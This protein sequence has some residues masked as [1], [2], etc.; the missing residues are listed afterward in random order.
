MEIRGGRPMSRLSLFAT[1]AV[2]LILPAC[3]SVNT[4]MGL[5]KAEFDRVFAAAIDVSSAEHCGTKV[6]AGLVRSNLIAAQTQRGLPIGQVESSG[7]VFDKT[8]NEYKGRIASQ[9]S[10]CSTDF[11]PELSQIAAYEKGNFPDVP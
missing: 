4:V 10:F 3:G 2:S 1:T 5:P 9:A 6:D 7:L 8:R 11:K